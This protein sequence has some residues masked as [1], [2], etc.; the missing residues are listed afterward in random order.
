MIRS[1]TDGVTRHGWGR[2]NKKGTSRRRTFSA[3]KGDVDHGTLPGHEAGQGPD[4]VF[5]DVDG[6]AD[7]TLAAEQR[8][9]RPEVETWQLPGFN[10]TVLAAA[11][12]ECDSLGS[13][14]P[15]MRQSWQ[16]PAMSIHSRVGL[17]RHTV[18]AVLRTV[19]LDGVKDFRVFSIFDTKAAQAHA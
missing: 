18:M 6:V 13:C 12:L 11:R 19:A 8:D 4:L 9:V 15:S 3:A 16:L 10:A 14:Q 17:R 1:S 7:A 2:D 5:V